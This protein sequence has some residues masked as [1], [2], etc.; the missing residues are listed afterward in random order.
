MRQEKTIARGN[1]LTKHCFW[2]VLLSIKMQAVCPAEGKFHERRR[3]DKRQAWFAKRDCLHQWKTA[4]AARSRV[5]WGHGTLSKV[6]WP[7]RVAPPKSA[8]NTTPKPFPEDETFDIGNGTRSGFALLEY[9]YHP[10]LKFAG[11][12][13]NTTLN[14]EPEQLTEEHRKSIPAIAHAVAC[15]KG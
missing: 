13:N 4:S 10:P 7:P 2:T 1:G 15:A 6:L 9:Y 3:N 14:L 5:R 8:P 12:I 11:K